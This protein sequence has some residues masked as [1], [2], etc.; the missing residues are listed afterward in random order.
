[1]CLSIFGVYILQWNYLEFGDYIALGLLALCASIC[2]YQ[3]ETWRDS[4]NIPQ[5]KRDEFW[6]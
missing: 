3:A 1:M 2:F 4:N 5:H 6:D